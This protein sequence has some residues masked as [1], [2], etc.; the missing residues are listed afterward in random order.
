MVDFALLVNYVVLNQSIC[1][2]AVKALQ[3]PRHACFDEFSKHIYGANVIK[4][5]LL[6]GYDLVYRDMCIFHGCC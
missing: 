3:L 5:A 2:A 4:F 6:E 1:S